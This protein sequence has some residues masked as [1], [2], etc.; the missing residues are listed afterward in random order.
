MPS[1]PQWSKWELIEQFTAANI[2]KILIVSGAAIG[3]AFI[4]INRDIE[5]IAANEIVV[6]TNLMEQSNNNFV[7]GE[8]NDRIRMMQLREDTIQGR[9]DTV[10]RVIATRPANET[11]PYLVDRDEYVEQIRLIKRDIIDLQEIN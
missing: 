9:L 4:D 3:V 1:L 2:A 8:R 7:T 10:N 6:H 11:L 5:K